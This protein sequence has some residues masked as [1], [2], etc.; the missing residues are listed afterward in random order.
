LFPRL[1]PKLFGKPRTP[2]LLSYR[3]TKSIMVP[4][5]MT[6]AARLSEQAVF[7]KT[8]SPVVNTSSAIFNATKRGAR[9]L[10]NA[11]NAMSIPFL[12][13]SKYTTS[14]HSISK[15]AKSSTTFSDVTE[16]SESV[17]NNFD[18]LSSAE[19]VVLNARRKQAILILILTKLQ[20]AVRQHV[21]RKNLSRTIEHLQMLKYQ[22][23]RRVYDME[24]RI[25]YLSAAMIQ[26]AYR[27]KVARQ[28]YL[29][30]QSAAIRLEAVQRGRKTL[31]A[32][33]LVQAVII[34]V[35]SVCRRYIVRRL[36]TRVLRSR[37]KLYRHHLFFIWQHCQRPLGYRTKFWSWLRCESALRVVVAEDEIRR[38]WDELD[39]QPPVFLTNNGADQTITIA[40]KLGMIQQ[41]YCT[42]LG[43]SI[44][45][46]RLFVLLVFV[47]TKISQFVPM[48]VDL[49][50]L[51][52]KIASANGSRS[53]PSARVRAERLQ[54][55]EKLQANTQNEQKP[56]YQRIFGLRANEK[57]KI[58]AFSQ[59]I[60]EFDHAVFFALRMF[61]RCTHCR[62]SCRG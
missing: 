20:Q 32:Y 53:A 23:P 46:L 12:K 1:D 61:Q 29:S 25:E 11:I 47:T 62:V 8:I 36:Y 59:T 21:R 5:R 15:S 35:Q 41:M 48:Q 14:E 38:I 54:I 31:Y 55:F 56:A 22:S 39:I 42:V 30:W 16:Q 51:T 34:R 13:S 3:R 19:A 60:C 58:L 6:D 18:F 52:D 10:E 49:N 40:A 17:H 9:N 7:A 28:K 2:R 33:R 45:N 24:T 27:C 50:D 4:R 43:V 57:K 26:A 37:M 44:A